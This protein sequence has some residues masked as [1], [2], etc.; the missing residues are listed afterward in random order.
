MIQSVW[1][2]PAFPLAA[3]LV[4]VLFGR[5][6][7]RRWTGPVAAAAIAASALVAIG[8]F[9]EVRNGAERTVVPLYTF[10]STGDFHVNVSALVDPLS[11][12]MLN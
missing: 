1:L 2:I 6:W 5:R 7:L 12:A 8:V 10:I 11:S 4:N 9:L 3:F